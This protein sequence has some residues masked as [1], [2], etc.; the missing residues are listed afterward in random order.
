M[1]LRY[2]ISGHGLGHAS[3]SL[4]IISA[5]RR[6]HP[7]LA[8]EIVSS[9]APWFLRD[10]AGGGIAIRPAAFDI[11][12]VQR[13]SLEMD[14]PATCQAWL[15]LLERRD[16]LL[17]AEAESLLRGGV[18]LVAADIPALPLAAARLAGI[19]AIG[20]SNFT[21]DWICD[22]FAAE[23]PAFAGIAA[24]LAADY[25]AADRFLALPFHGAFPPGPSVEPLPLVA[26]KAT[27]PAATI[28]PALGLP[29]DKRVAL[30]S[31]GGFGLA[32]FDFSPLA[33]LEQWIFLSEPALAAKASNLRVIPPGACPYPELVAA[34][35]VVV[36][37]PG[38]GIVSEAIA[39]QTAVLYTERGNFREQGL[40]VAGLHRYT[41]ALAIDN[42][43]LRSGDW[44]EALDALVRQPEAPERLAA[45]GDVQAA[46]RLAAL[47]MG[48]DKER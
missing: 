44:G 35:D 13:D 7:Q 34:A 15:D 9:A 6:R 46:D 8:V 20:L 37:K 40:L 17:A 2:Y 26:R 36:T 10:A 43:R 42:R 21:W 27:G 29:D 47:A 18:S 25:A 45:D 28:R 4:Q 30:I 39:N 38:Y 16:A 1:R 41:R 48:G 19:P 14:L 3:R 22:G 33:R 12:V 32:D 11:G 31:F 5:L 23:E 24:A